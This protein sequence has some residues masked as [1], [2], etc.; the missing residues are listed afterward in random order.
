MK[1]YSKSK[2]KGS[3][4]GIQKKKRRV[5][6]RPNLPSHYHIKDG[7]GARRILQKELWR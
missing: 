4:R 1:I 5:E 6:A 7:F 3:P 2:R